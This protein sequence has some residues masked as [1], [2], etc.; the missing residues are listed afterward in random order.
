MQ[1]VDEIVP[2][3]LHALED[4]DTS[5]TALDGLKQILSVRTAA[6]LPHILPKLVHPPLTYVFFSAWILSFSVMG[7]IT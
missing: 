2:A 3:L 4:D 6:V 1:A 7:T 5:A